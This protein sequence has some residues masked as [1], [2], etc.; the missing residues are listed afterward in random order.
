[1]QTRNQDSLISSSAGAEFKMSK[2]TLEGGSLHSQL[3]VV[4][5]ALS[6]AG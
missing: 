5:D 6:L 4:A 3:C 2:E 1:M